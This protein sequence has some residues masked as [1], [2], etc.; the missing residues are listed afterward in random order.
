MILLNVDKSSRIPVFRQITDRIVELVKEGTLPPGTRLPPTRVLAQRVGVNRSTVYRAYQDLWALGYIDARPGSYSTIRRR[1]DIV[2]DGASPPG[3]AFDWAG[4]SRPRSEELHRTMCSLRDHVAAPA[5]GVIRFS[6]LTA[7]RDLG[8]AEELKSSIRQVFAREGRGLLDYGDPAGYKPLR[9]TISRRMRTHGVTVGADE[10]LI[11]N[12]SQQAVDLV[13]RLLTEPGSRIAIETPTYALA[14]PLIRLHGLRIVGIPMRDNGMDLEV[15]ERR[16]ATDRPA[17]VYTIPSFHNPTG[18]TTDQAHRERLLSLCQELGVPIVEDGFE[19][20]M[21]YSG[22]VVLP[23]RSMDVHGSVVYL[24]TFSKVVFPGLRIGWIAAHRECIQR[25]L[26]IQRFTCL[27]LGTVGQVAVHR[28][29]EQGL[30]EEHIRRVHRTYRKRMQAMIESLRA[31]LPRGVVRWTE[32]TGGYTLW[33]DLPGVTMDES[34][35][36]ARLCGAGVA[37]T[38]GSLFFPSRPKVISFRMSIS[39]LTEPDIREGIRRLAGVLR[40]L[41]EV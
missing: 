30:Y 13:L 32:P 1:M 25:L 3:G 2:T 10:I 38:P 40:P 8:P 11:T 24:G 20:E 31:E 27:S 35:F 18:I 4:V 22:K 12:G 41:V 21:K 28:F 36:M 17:L 15:L 5:P 6:S 9:E 26:A 7:D 19:E 33:V 14:L 34:Q 29:C 37:V 23:I 16:L 39:N